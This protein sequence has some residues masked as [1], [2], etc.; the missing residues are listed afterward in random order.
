MTSYRGFGPD[1]SAKMWPVHSLE[2]VPVAHRTCSVPSIHSKTHWFKPEY[3]L[4]D[5]WTICSPLS[6]PAAAGSDPCCLREPFPL[7]S[8]SKS[9]PCEGENYQESLP[10]ALFFP[11]DLGAEEEGMGK[12][13]R[14]EDWTG[15]WDGQHREELNIAQRL[16]ESLPFQLLTCNI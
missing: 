16:V 11:R 5:I 4:S 9:H 12:L 15:A 3:C 2:H 7:H 1:F 14:E 8:A 13:A 10:G 6:V